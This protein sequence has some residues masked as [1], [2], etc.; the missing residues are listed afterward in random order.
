MIFQK[1]LLTFIQKNIDVDITP[2]EDCYNDII[3]L[4]VSDANSLN[5]RTRMNLYEKLSSI[6]DNGKVVLKNLGLDFDILYDKVISS[7]GA[8]RPL[9]SLSTKQAQLF[10]KQ[11]LAN[12]NP[13]AENIL[14][15]FDFAKFGKMD[16]L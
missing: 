9:V 3:L 12:N 14:K 4:H 1:P 7:L 5:L 6:D 13:K 10:V 8:K 11:V 15:T 2:I 16:C